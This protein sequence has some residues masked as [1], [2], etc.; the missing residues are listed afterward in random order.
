[1]KASLVSVAQ[2]TRSLTEYGIGPIL[3]G[4]LGVSVYLGDFKQFGD[5][6]LLVD[7]PWVA[8]RWPQ[9]VGIMNN[10]DFKLVDPKEHEFEDGD[11]TKVAFADR[12]ILQRD[13]V[14]TS[15][16]EIVS[17]KVGDLVI[18]TLTAHAFIRAYEFSK[19]DGYRRDVRQKNDDRI[20]DLLR[21]YIVNR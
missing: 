2:L 13:G 5:V 19:K 20:I 8:E 1:M 12:S 9:L 6:D 17:K 16:E 14:I 7:A 21:G 18:R 3:Y 4:S 10:E 15:E 11:G